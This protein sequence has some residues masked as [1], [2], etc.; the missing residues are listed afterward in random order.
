MC[1]LT[2]YTNYQE[3]AELI[4]KIDKLTIIVAQLTKPIRLRKQKI[5][6]DDI[7]RFDSMMHTWILRDLAI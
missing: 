7:H 3:L 5:Q 2:E 4:N 1:M 6:I